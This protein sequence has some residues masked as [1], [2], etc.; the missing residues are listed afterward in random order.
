MN[1]SDLLK[2]V[3]TLVVAFLLHLG[4]KAIGVEVDPVVFDTIVAGIVT[5]F[6]TLFLHQVAVTLLPRAVERGFLSDK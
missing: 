2:A 3:L 6:L 4:F 5:W 1:I